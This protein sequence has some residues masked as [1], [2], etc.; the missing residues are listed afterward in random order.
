MSDFNTFGQMAGVLVGT[1]AEGRTKEGVL[2]PR[3]LEMPGTQGAPC[4]VAVDLKQGVSE[5]A[6]SS[7]L[8]PRVSAI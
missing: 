1:L 4:G 5:D 3:S 2:A 6:P 7:P 8:I